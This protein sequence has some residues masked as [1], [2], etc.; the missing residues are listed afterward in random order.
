MAFCAFSWYFVFF[1]CEAN[2]IVVTYS[3]LG[4]VIGESGDHKKM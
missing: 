1:S 2:W 4:V 3:V